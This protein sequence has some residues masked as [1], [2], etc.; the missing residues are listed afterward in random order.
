MAYWFTKF[1][2]SSFGHSRDMNEDPKRKNT[3]RVIEVIDNVN[4]R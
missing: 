1:E 2:D 4:I 3:V